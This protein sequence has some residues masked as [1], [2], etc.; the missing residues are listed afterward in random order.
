MRRLFLILAALLCAAAFAFASLAQKR[1]SGI[2]LQL[3]TP[4]SAT[5]AAQLS[6]QEA[7]EAQSVGFSFY[8]ILEGQ[9][10]TCPDTGQA[11]E[12]TVVPVYG[13]GSLL[14]A[15]ALSW[16]KG[17]V[18]DAD[19]AQALF[20]TDAVGGQQVVLVDETLPVLAAGPALTP[21]ALISAGQE[22]RLDRC[23]LAGWDGNG[24]QTAEQ[25]LFRH[26]LSG[27]ILNFYPL[28]VFVRNFCLLPL[29]VLLLS[30]S[31]LAGKRARWLGWLVGLAGAALLGKWVIVPED[32]I[33]SVWSDFSFWGHWLR[34]QKENLLSIFAWAPVERALQMEQ[35][36][37]KSVLCTMAGTLAAVIGG[38]R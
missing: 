35:N 15:D 6:A 10:L 26:G 36:M 13:N 37:I 2:F 8:T 18:L 14:G 22:T 27:E 3:E 9:R 24:G 5:Q 21:V 11:A 4:I 7:E 16:A 28:L 23:V 25:F 30:L 33:P 19:T 32:A 31:R 20:G 34:A 1:G 38:R 29:W 17:C 12:V